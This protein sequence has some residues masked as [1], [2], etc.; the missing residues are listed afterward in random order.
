MQL[1]CKR[2]GYWFHFKLVSLYIGSA[3][4]GE[5]TIDFPYL[6]TINCQSR[7]LYKPL[8]DKQPLVRLW[9]SSASEI[10]SYKFKLKFESLC[11]IA[12]KMV[13]SQFERR[14]SFSPPLR[15]PGDSRLGRLYSAQEVLLEFSFV[16]L[17]LACFLL[18]TSG[19]RLLRDDAYCNGFVA[20]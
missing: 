12:K 10:T 11:A 17:V 5:V 6:E 20:I 16:V 3:R 18:I 14:S 13:H 9:K 7:V 1:C 15:T 4:C 19:S 2:T 8:W